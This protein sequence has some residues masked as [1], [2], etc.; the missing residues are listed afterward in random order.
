MTT[1]ESASAVN[2][3][4]IHDLPEPVR[5]CLTDFCAAA[6]AAFGAEL[7]SI[8]LFGSAAEGRL[9]ATSDVNVIV[10]LRAFER[11]AV[12]RIREPLRVAAAAVRLGPMFL[13]ESEIL[14]AAE[15]FAAKFADIVHRR[16]VLVGDD[17][18]SDL[19][20][21]R[22][23]QLARLKQIL[24]NLTLRLR[25]LYAERSLREE[26]LARVLADETGPLRVAAAT[27]LELEGAPAASPKE[28]L[29]RIAGPEAAG[30]GDA[31]SAA[32]D[33]RGLAEGAAASAA[34]QIFGVLHA[35][36][37]RVARLR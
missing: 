17:P 2:P 9:R 12:D 22:A 4:A 16:R 35:M 11:G 25:A 14:A 20:V 26:Q 8:V 10:V 5:R 30:L 21:S 29:Q 15:A 28:A 37:A 33:G 36:D 19:A 1:T 3:A 18:F 13:L 7:R 27:L 32:R 31:L 34:F 24:L 6:G 23:A